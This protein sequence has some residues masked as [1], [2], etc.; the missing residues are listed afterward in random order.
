MGRDDD[1]CD[2]PGSPSKSKILL[3]VNSDDEDG[4]SSSNND[5]CGL[6]RVKS[7]PDIVD[8]LAISIDQKSETGRESMASEVHMIELELNEKHETRVRLRPAKPNQPPVQQRYS[9]GA[10]DQQQPTTRSSEPSGASPHQLSS[11][12][13][14]SNQSLS[15]CSFSF[16]EVS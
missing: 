11:S 1:D 13:S 10:L 12:C 15:N 6:Y 2:E 7:C 4:A 5:E 9:C 8:Q 14:G 16:I 3:F